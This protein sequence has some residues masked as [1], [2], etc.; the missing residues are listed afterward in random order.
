[1]LNPESKLEFGKHRGLKWKDVPEEYIQ[2]LI[3]TRKADL[4]DY[5]GEL[6]RRKSLEEANL[7]MTERIVKAG[8]KKL[9]QELHPDHGGNPEE[10][11]SLKGS[12]EALMGA[13]KDSK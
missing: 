5:E 7:S 4:A 9:S 2:W 8:W 10:F 1:M 12:F 13:I 11:L 3:D 6:E